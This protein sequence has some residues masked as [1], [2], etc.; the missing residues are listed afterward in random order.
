M[1]ETTTQ[2]IFSLGDMFNAWQRD[3][4]DAKAESKR[5]RTFPFS[6]Q[7]LEALFKEAVTIKVLTEKMQRQWIESVTSG[8]LE[9]DL[10]VDI[11]FHRAFQ[12]WYTQFS[13]LRRLIA[14]LADGGFVLR[15]SEKLLSHLR[16]SEEVLAI[17][18]EPVT[19]VAPIRALQPGGRFVDVSRYDD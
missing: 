16:W 3:H 14:Y 8:V 6:L 7:Q 15:H 5:D 1:I 12:L 2:R 10:A 18:K 13:P 19:A 4:S 9:P 17:T 11:E